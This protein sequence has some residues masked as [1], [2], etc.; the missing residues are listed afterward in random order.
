[1]DVLPSLFQTHFNEILIGGYGLSSKKL[2]KE[3]EKRFLSLEWTYNYNEEK[4]TLRIED[5]EKRGVSLQLSNTLAKWKEQGDTAIDALVYYIEQTLLAMQQTILLKEHTKSIYQVIR[6]TSFPTE[7]NEGVPLLYEEHTAETRIY[8]AVDIGASYKL[9]DKNMLDIDEIQVKEIAKFNV[10]SLPISYKEDTVAGN[11]F[12]FV[13]TNDGYDASRVLND[14]FLQSMKQKITGTMALGIPHQD[15]LII[16]DI[17]ND[18]GYD[19][20]AQMATGFFMKGNIPITALSFIYEEGILE[21]MFILGK[22][23]K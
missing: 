17:Q 3:I 12:Y 19:V 9:I 8:Y 13:N 2:I 6:S 15:V 22:R 21:P 5:N 4:D 16:A 1:M 18:V 20:L 10:R 14:S 7:S 11:T 23:K